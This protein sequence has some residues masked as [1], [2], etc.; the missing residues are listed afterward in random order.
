MERVIIHV[1]YIEAGKASL[2]FETLCR[3]QAFSPVLTASLAGL[4]TKTRSRGR[5]LF[6]GLRLFES[7]AEKA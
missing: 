7:L 5:A 1:F 6:D 3:V 2:S 4:R